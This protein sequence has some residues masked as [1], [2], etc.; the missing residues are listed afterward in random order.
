MNRNDTTTRVVPRAAAG[1]FAVAGETFDEW[2]AQ[3]GRVV[4]MAVLPSIR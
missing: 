3:W 4:A 1:S 2:P